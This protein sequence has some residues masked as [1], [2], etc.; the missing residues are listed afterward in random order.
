MQVSA[1]NSICDVTFYCY[2]LI[3]GYQKEKNVKKSTNLDPLFNGGP[4]PETLPEADASQIADGNI[5]PGGDSQQSF[6]FS[7][8]V[9][10]KHE[11][12]RTMVQRKLHNEI[13]ETTSHSTV[14]CSI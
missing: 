5:D 12:T 14:K 4:C 3:P 1:V 6:S 13:S 7:V 11:L 8:L 2:R 10:S 9:V